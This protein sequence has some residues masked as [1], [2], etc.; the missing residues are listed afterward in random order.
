[1]NEWMTDWIIEWTSE[2]S[3]SFNSSDKWID[4]RAIKIETTTMKWHKCMTIKYNIC[5]KLVLKFFTK[6]WNDFKWHTHMRSFFFNFSS[7]LCY[8]SS[9][10]S[11]TF[12]LTP[13]FSRSITL[14]NFFKILKIAPFNLFFFEIYGLRWGRHLWKGNKINKQMRFGFLANYSIILVKKKRKINDN[15][16]LLNYSLPFSLS[17]SLTLFVSF[18]L[19]SFYGCVFFLFQNFSFSILFYWLSIFP[20]YFKIRWKN[21]NFK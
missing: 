9:L 2:W 8:F 6:I 12:P 14:S 16:Y 5:L 21:W 20:F 4:K 7:F 1:M 15:L 13:H 18:S 19:S 11:T 17:I 3:S 10:H